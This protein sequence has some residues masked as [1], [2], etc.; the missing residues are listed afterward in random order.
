MFSVYS[1][2]CPST[3][4]PTCLIQKAGSGPQLA[5]AVIS[6]PASVMLSLLTTA[7]FSAVPTCSMFIMMPPC[8]P[9][10]IVAMKSL[11]EGI[12]W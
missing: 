5:L 7:V 9:N 10:P 8:H 6:T 2:I 4:P 1:S 11:S 3:H 12:Y